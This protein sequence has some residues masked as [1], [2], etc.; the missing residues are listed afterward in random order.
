MIG[1]RRPSRLVPLQKAL[2]NQGLENLPPFSHP[3]KVLDDLRGQ[4]RQQGGSEQ[5][6][7][8]GF[9]QTIE[10]LARE[11]VNGALD[12]ILSDRPGCESLRLASSRA[13]TNPATHRHA[14]MKEGGSVLF[15]IELSPLCQDRCRFLWSQPEGGP[16]HGGERLAAR[17]G[18]RARGTPLRPMNTTLIPGGSSSSPKAEEL[19]ESPIPAALWQSSRTRTHGLSM[20]PKR[21]SKNL[22]EE[23]AVPRVVLEEALAACSPDLAAAAAR[24]REKAGGSESRSSRRYQREGRLRASR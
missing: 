24:V 16:A 4:K 7:P 1:R 12:E 17:R 22:R 11:V 19:V 2:A 14:C 10:D 9:V 3:G 6:P 8:A 13:R 18:K 15:F 23:N 5:K 20:P 21:A